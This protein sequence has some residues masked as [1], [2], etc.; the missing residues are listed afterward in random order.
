MIFLLLMLIAYLDYYYYTANLISSNTLKSFTKCIRYRVLNFT[1][2]TKYRV[3][4][5]VVKAA[6]SAREDQS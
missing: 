1:T 2:T 4:Y 6:V 3:L 5:Y